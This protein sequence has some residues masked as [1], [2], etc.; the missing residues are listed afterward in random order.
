[1]A[2]FQAGAPTGVAVAQLEVLGRTAV[3]KSA[4][5]LVGWLLQQA[6]RRIDD[7]YQPKPGEERKGPETIKAQGICGHF[8]PTRDDYYHAGKKQGHHPADNALGLEVSYTPALAKLLCWE[9]A[10]E[11]T[12]RKAERHLEQPGGICVSARQIQ[13]VVQ[14]LGPE[15]QTWQEREVAPAQ[16]ETSP[17]PVFYVSADG[18]G[19]PMRPEELEGRPGKRADGK[20]KTRQGSLGGGFTQP[21]LDEG[22]SPGRDWESTPDVSSLDS[23]DQ[24][25]P[26]RRR[27]ARRRG[28]GTALKVV[29]PIDG[30]EGLANM[31][32]LCFKGAVPIVDFFHALEHAGE[33]LVALWGS[34]D[35][36]EYEPRL[37]RWADRLLEDEV[38]KLIAETRHQA[39]QAGRSE[40]VEKELGDFVRNVG[41][42]LYGTFRNR[43][44]FIGSGAIEAGCQTVIGTRCKQSGL[45]W[46][47]PGA[48]NSLA[49]R[50][51]HASRR[52]DNFWKY[53][54]N[55]HATLNDS[56]P[57]AA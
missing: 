35:H 10:D 20:A 25:G 26:L 43:G 23:I 6:A 28:M 15:A 22:G 52:L 38:E 54:L 55:Q 53:R 49:F 45:F 2:R 34:K 37:H 24:F 5:E 27:E 19:I 14:R 42:M 32:T 46:G 13:R 9:G 30:A 33:V 47:A 57:L 56:L 4:N 11:A 12:Y 39:T 1:M 48:E 36:P 7:A 17:V 41:R 16:C 18:T 40:P 8:E 51:I 3:F 21:R 44:F 29:R 50:G 31:G